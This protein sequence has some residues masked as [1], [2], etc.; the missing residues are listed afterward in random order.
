MCAAIIGGAMCGDPEWAE[1]HAQNQS[2]PKD[3]TR[4]Q[5]VFEAM[6]AARCAQEFA[7]QMS[8]D[9]TASKRML[10]EVW[11]QV[12][13]AWSRCAEIMTV[14]EVV[15]SPVDTRDGTDWQAEATALAEHMNQAQRVIASM[16]QRLECDS[17]VIT[18]EAWE[19]MNGAAITVT[20]TGD[21]NR[22]IRR[23]S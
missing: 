7:D 12:S 2:G 21:G 14:S 22:V 8:T 11:A 17:I 4:D 20:V 1:H 10:A 9:S 23:A 15:M 6:N 16:F 13:V 18:G 3:M 5:V 19:R